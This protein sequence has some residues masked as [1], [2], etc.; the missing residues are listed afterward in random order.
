MTEFSTACT[1]RG[2]LPTAD[3]RLK[4]AE[5]A[6][7]GPLSDATRDHSPSA[8]PTS[9]SRV[10]HIQQ[11]RLCSSL[12]M[13]RCSASSASAP[14]RKFMKSSTQLANSVVGNPGTPPNQRR[15]W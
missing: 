12:A 11:M 10:A 2:S 9:S 14:M 3:C 6:V 8:V 13:V 5:V 15:F 4:A 1:G 7:M